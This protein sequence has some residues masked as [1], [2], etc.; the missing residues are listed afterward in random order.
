M[1]SWRGIVYKEHVS[2][3]DAHHRTGAY[4]TNTRLADTWPDVEKGGALFD[5]G[6]HASRRK[7]VFCD[8]G[9]LRGCTV[10]DSNERRKRAYK[11]LDEVVYTLV[12][13]PEPRAWIRVRRL[14]CSTHHDKRRCE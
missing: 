10:M 2:L 7:V 1:N 4:Y 14:S 9:T 12:V 6:I 8:T 3:R 13:V 11:V 5:D